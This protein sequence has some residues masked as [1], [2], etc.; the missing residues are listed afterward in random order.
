MAEWNSQTIRRLL[1]KGKH[2]FTVRLLHQ[3]LLYI[4]IFISYLPSDYFLRTNC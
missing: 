2:V 3:D 1:L 4:Y